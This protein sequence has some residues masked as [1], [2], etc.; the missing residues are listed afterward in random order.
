[1]FEARKI[2]QPC[3]QKYFENIME[4]ISIRKF[5]LVILVFL[6]SRLLIKF[7][8]GAISKTAVQKRSAVPR[9]FTLIKY[10]GKA[11]M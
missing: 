10:E 5:L 11:F 4:K 6:F 9:I 1:M 2:W 7:I 8:Q 3:D